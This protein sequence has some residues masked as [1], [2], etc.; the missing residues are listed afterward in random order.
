MPIRTD[1]P[2][3]AGPVFMT[4]LP[5]LRPVVL[6]LEDRRPRVIALDGEIVQPVL[7]TVSGSLKCIFPGFRE[8]RVDPSLVVHRGGGNLQRPACLRH[9][10]AV[11]QRLTELALDSPR[12]LSLA[13]FWA[14]YAVLFGCRAGGPASQPLQTAAR[15]ELGLCCRQARKSKVPRPS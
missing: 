4:V 13:P 7:V 11:G 9:R 10:R 6:E 14:V 2:P 8:L 12:S 5:L 3:K 15:E 1:L